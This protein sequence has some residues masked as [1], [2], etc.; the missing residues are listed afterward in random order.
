[1]NIK[2]FFKKHSDVLPMGVLL[3]LASLFIFSPLFVKTAQANPDTFCTTSSTSGA[4]SSPAYLAFGTSLATTTLY[5]SRGCSDDVYGAKMYTLL[6]QFIA[7]TSNSTFVIQ[8][9]Y[10]H[11]VNGVDCVANPT[12]CDW[13]AGT[14]TTINDYATSTG[15]IGT[16]DFAPIPN[17][18]YDFASSTVGGIGTG[19][20]GPNNLNNRDTKVLMFPAPTQYSRWIISLKTVTASNG[21]YWG[22]VIGKKEIGER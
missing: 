6:N 17:F 8:Q 21:A 15:V 4:T 22:M 5:A 14:F 12:G 16:L 11:G 18:V 20:R 3:L 9:E 13:Y 1:M 10:A 19:M 2:T 7:S